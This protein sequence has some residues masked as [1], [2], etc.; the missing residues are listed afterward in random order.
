MAMT[1]GRVSGRSRFPAAETPGAPLVVAVH[2]GTYDTAYFD[3]PSHSLLD[4]AEAN[5]VPIVAVDRQGYGDTPLAASAE[6]TL[7]DQ[8]RFLTAALTDIWAEHGH[9]RP[10]IVL[11]GHSI[12]AAIA[13]IAV[14]RTTCRSS[15][16]PCRA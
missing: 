11:I 4:R 2:G 7:V 9:S 5:G 1:F 16:S 6:M 3:V 14:G 8:A 12:G 10:G 13:L 15:V